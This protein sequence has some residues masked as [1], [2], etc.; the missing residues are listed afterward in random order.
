MHEKVEAAKKKKR[1]TYKTFG[2]INIDL[3][4]AWVCGSVSGMGTVTYIEDKMVIR[5]V[6]P[7]VGYRGRRN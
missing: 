6:N 5:L 2:V 4:F 7:A 3:L 1:C